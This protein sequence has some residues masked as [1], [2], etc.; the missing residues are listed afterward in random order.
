MLQQHDKKVQ[1]LCVAGAR[2][3][4]CCTWCLAQCKGSRQQQDGVLCQALQTL[5][6]LAGT[7]YNADQPCS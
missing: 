2:T 3:S 5:F 7:A 4:S 6:K 1:L